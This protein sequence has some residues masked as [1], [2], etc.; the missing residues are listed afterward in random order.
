VEDIFIVV[1]NNH[2]LI[3]SCPRKKYR[4]YVILD[5]LYVGRCLYS[6]CVGNRV[7]GCFKFIFLLV[8][9]E[10]FLTKL[11]ELRICMFLTAI[12]DMIILFVC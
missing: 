10:L 9:G 3:T 11:L 8:V 5:F 7:L 1:L 6:L 4:I 12:A 2:H